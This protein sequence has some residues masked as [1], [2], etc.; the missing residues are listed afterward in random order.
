VGEP[1]LTDRLFFALFPPAD[2]AAQITALLNALCVQHGL[3]GHP[4]TPERLHVTLHHIDDYAGLPPDIVRGALKAGEAL[5][6]SAIELAFDEVASFSS[7][8]RKPMLV[9]RGS[10]GVPAVVA[11]QQALGKTINRHLPKI[12]LP[13]SYTPHMTMLYG[14]PRQ[15]DMRQ[16]EQ[17]IEPIRWTATEVVLVHSLLGK[18]RHIPLARWSLPQSVR[19]G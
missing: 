6:A 17:P 1:A 16:V 19:T 5:A 14:D 3:R 2:V 18:S 12:R 15:G 8:P 7:N 11:V 9:L 10:D 4:V 13:A